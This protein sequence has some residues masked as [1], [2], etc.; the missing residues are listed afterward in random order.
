M[1]MD[2]DSKLMYGLDYSE[3]VKHLDED[4]IEQLDNDLDDGDIDY[5]SPYY[6]SDREDWF[7]GVSLRQDITVESCIKQMNNAED[8]FKE[9][10]GVSGVVRGCA[11]VW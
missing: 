4:Q 2:I 6:D 3:L 1:G 9:R 10:F 7:V 11:H 5:A 8:F